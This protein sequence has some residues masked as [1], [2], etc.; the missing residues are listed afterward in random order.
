MPWKPSDLLTFRLADLVA[1]ARAWFQRFSRTVFGRLLAVFAL[2]LLMDIGFG[3][4]YYSLYQG[5]P[6]RFLFADQV[7]SAQRA[8]YRRSLM[9]EVATTRDQSNALKTFVASLPANDADVS[10]RYFPLLGGTS[11]VLY[12][13]RG[14]GGRL[15]LDDLGGCRPSDR[16]PCPPGSVAQITDTAGVTVAEVP[17][18]AG[19]LPRMTTVATA[20]QALASLGVD[21]GSRV[22]Q[23]QSEL[24]DESELT[25]HSW[26]FVDFLYF[27]TITQ[28]TVG[29]GDMVPNSS[30]VRFAVMLQL[31]VSVGLLIVVLNL[32]LNARAGP[33]P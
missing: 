32:V 5:N 19:S 21:L 22:A 28:M 10:F 27:S 33:S 23:L 12:E 2:Y 16:M 4:L 30:E 1:R 26:R 6:A 9:A 24:A 17:V 31:V 14:P 7:A 13:I 8:S 15:R 29:Y 18:T 11:D 25:R 20:R 3:W